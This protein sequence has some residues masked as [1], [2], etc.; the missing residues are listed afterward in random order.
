[1]EHLWA[2]NSGIGPN[3]SSVPP[4]TW[5]QADAWRQS[6]G[7]DHHWDKLPRSISDPLNA[8]S[9]GTFS[10]IKGIKWYRVDRTSPRTHQPSRKSWS[11]IQKHS[12]E[13]VRLIR[14]TPEPQKILTSVCH[15]DRTLQL[16]SSVLAHCDVSRLNVSATAPDVSTDESGTDGLIFPKGLRNRE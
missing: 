2:P 6:S 13:K 10:S 12:W 4:G 5:T 15:L 16:Q 11:E 8:C 9:C 3:V 1:M 7:D 14:V